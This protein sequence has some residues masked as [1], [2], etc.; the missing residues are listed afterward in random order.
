MSAFEDYCIVC[1]KICPSDSVYCSNGCKLSDQQATT[2]PTLSSCS[3]HTHNNN[4]NNIQFNNGPQLIS[5]LLTPQ[6]Y[7]N[8]NISQQL[9]ESNN[10]TSPHF[11]NNNQQHLSIA[12][13]QTLNTSQS[14]KGLSYESPLLACSTNSNSCLN[15][16]DSNRL[17]LNTPSENTRRR[18]GNK[19]QINQS[20]PSNISDILSNTSENYKKWLNSSSFIQ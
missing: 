17:D 10:I 11:N 5:P 6:L 7:N 14:F 15:D 8:N 13:H 1:E 3:V 18:S 19:L 20:A 2:S 12:H 4:N 16:L 9:Q